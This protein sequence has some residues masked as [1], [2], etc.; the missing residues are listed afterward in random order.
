MKLLIFS[1]IDGTFMNHDNYSY[2]HL[3]NYVLKIKNKSLIVF[4]SSKTFSEIKKINYNLK[5]NVPF[6]V[7]NGACIFFPKNFL[8]KKPITSSFFLQNDFLGYKI[9]KKNS[10]F[11]YNSLI[12]IKRNFNLSFSFFRELSDKQLQEITGLE[13]NE[14]KDSKDRLF[15]EPIYWE[16]SD[17]KFEEFKKQ[18]E[19]IGGLINVGGRFVHVTDGYDKGKAVKEFLKLFK[20][21]FNDEYLSV[22][23]G[24]SQ[25]DISMLELTDYRCIIKSKKKNLDLKNKKNLY[26]SKNIAPKGWSESLDYIFKKEKINF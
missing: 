16:D 15:S 12:E 4:N 7:E 26:H 8:K 3:K 25:N 14:L 23:L 21:N 24:D 2:S 1:D 10:D 6:I 5:I 11:W 9:S 17:N 22:S 20:E 18:V 19:L 13:Q